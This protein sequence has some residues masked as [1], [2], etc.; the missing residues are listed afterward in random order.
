MPWIQ[1]TA[2]DRGPVDCPVP[3]MWPRT[4]S[5]CGFVLVHKKRNL[6]PRLVRARPGGHNR[7]Y[8]V[9]LRKDVP[10]RPQMQIFRGRP[11]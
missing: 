1:T 11:R 7:G 2:N 5:R 8:G 4:G 6:H 10:L 3:D 9:Q